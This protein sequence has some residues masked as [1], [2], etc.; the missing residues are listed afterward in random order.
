MNRAITSIYDL[1]PSFLQDLWVSLYGLKIYRREYGRKLQEELDQFITRERVSKGELGKYQNER[2]R[3]LIRH[4]YEQVPYYRKVMDE[5]G[6]KPS[7]IQSADDLGK[8]PVLTRSDVR[9]NLSTLTARN[10][11]RSQLILGHTSGTTGSPLTFYYDERACLIKNVVDWRQKSWAGIHPGDKVAFFL[12]RVVVP[13]TRS[14][15]PFWKTNWFLNHL[16]FSSFHLSQEN[17]NAY[18]RKLY[19]FRPLAVEGY[20]S[21]MYIIA[22]CLLSQNRTYPAKAVFTSSETLHPQQREAI[23][24]AF[25]CKLYDFYGI[26]ERVVFATE[27]EKHEGKHLNMDFGITEILGRDEQ[28]VETG[29]IGRIVSTG[30]HNFAMPLIRYRTDD[31]TSLAEADCSCGRSLPLMADVTTKAEDIITTKDGRYVSS[32]ILTH[33]FKPLHSVVESQIVQED[34]DHIM[35]K[36]VKSPSYQDKDTEY[37]INELK[38]RVGNDMKVEVEFV[39]SIPRTKAGKFRWVISKVP[40][41]F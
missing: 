27:C 12:G 37:L 38:L 10:F 32:S 17:L 24:T 31:I 20:P 6:L 4:C 9:N 30:L 33:P 19:E 2:L 25:E 11:R 41:E 35:V 3:A 13:I 23:E 34:R 40:L 15:P 36:I 7:D 18:V 28:P 14:K 1:S 16:F 29:E 22:R 26:A 8:M 5:R 21:T 39:D